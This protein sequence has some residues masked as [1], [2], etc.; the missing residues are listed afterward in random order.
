MLNKGI[1]QNTAGLST[2]AVLSFCNAFAKIVGFYGSTFFLKI[3]YE[4]DNK[5][6]NVIR[7]FKKSD[8]L[9][10]LMQISAWYKFAILNNLHTEK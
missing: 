1:K 4:T 5:C 2:I 3:Q 10:Q 7:C 6:K 9:Q 8:Q